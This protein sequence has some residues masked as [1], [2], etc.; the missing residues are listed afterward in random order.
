MSFPELKLMTDI[1]AEEINHL[2]QV[3]FRDVQE[4]RG[5]LC[6][7]GQEKGSY[8]QTTFSFR[9]DKFHMRKAQLSLFLKLKEEGFNMDEWGEDVTTS[10]LCHKKDCLK[11]EH[12]T[13]ESLEINRERDEC[14]RRRRCLGHKNRPHCLV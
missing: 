3:C 11:K 7:K 1:T 5:H 9:G 14:A 12:L 10:H 13:L 8:A 6:Y 4:V 2:N